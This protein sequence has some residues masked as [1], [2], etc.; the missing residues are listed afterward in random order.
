MV[1]GNQ[2]DRI[3]PVGTVELVEETWTSQELPVLAAIVEKS[4]DP[5]V[6]Q[7]RAPEVAALTGIDKETVIPE[8]APRVKGVAAGESSLIGK[9]DLHVP[10]RRHRGGV[11]AG[12]AAE[13]K[14]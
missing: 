4:D 14:P 11:K 1:C 10:A 8:G 9:L 2:V 7:I 6:S 5:D 12:A 3:N 13:G